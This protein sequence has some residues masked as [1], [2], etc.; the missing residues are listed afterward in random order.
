LAARV[1]NHSSIWFLTRFNELKQIRA[2]A[3]GTHRTHENKIR[4]E[5]EDQARRND[6]RNP[7]TPDFMAGCVPFVVKQCARNSLTSAG[8]SKCPATPWARR[9]TEN[10]TPSIIRHDGEYRFVGDVVADEERTAPP[11]GLVRHQLAHAG[12]L[13]ESGMLDLATTFRAALRSARSQIALI[14]DTAA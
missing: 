8:A 5:N 12:R 11:E 7:A 14:N 3:A 4:R 9:P 2:A 10:A 13:G 6:V 1:N